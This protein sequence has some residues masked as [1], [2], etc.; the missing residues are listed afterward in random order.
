MHPVSPESF[1][2]PQEQTPPKPRRE[3][4]QSQTPKQEGG[5]EGLRDNLRK[6]QLETKELMS[7]L[8]EAVAIQVNSTIAM[9]DK[10]NLPSDYRKAEEIAKDFLSTQAEYADY[11]TDKVSHILADLYISQE[12]YEEAVHLLADLDSK[13]LKDMEVLGEG[14]IKEWVEIRVYANLP[15]YERAVQALVRIMPE[16]VGKEAYLKLMQDI[17]KRKVK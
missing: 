4:I 9:G 7:K 3:Q 2:P 5:V 11:M 16:G 10:S 8:E 12:R 17:E 1:Y 15:P 13:L 14:H 6:R